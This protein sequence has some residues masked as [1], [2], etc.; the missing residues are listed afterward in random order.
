MSDLAAV[1]EDI[2]EQLRAHSND[3][4]RKALMKAVPNFDGVY[5]VR[6]PVINEIAK[7]QKAGGFPLVTALWTS[8]SYAERMLAAKILG[9]NCR[10]DP[11][12]SIDLLKRFSPDVDNWA[13]CDTLCS[14]GIRPITKRNSEMVI[15]LA[16][17]FLESDLMWIRRMG[18][19]LLIHY[20]KIPGR[21]DE[22]RTMIEPLKSEKEHYI[23]K[24]IL[25]I[26][27]YLDK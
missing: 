22:I 14:E 17:S 27:R 5:S 4:A 12:G 9:F 20:A 25:W 13:I 18:V 2:R 15:G 6:M 21:K 23:K 8:G 3:E 11:E 24:A 19:V 16:Q 10:M 7:S 1:L 26:T